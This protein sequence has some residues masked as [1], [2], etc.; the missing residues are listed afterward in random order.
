MITMASAS[1]RP[2]I[3]DVAKI[4]GVSY[5]TVSRY[6]NGS[7]HVSE[8]AANRIAKAVKETSYTPNS[9]ARSLAHRRTQTI[10]LI[11]Q[12]ES[13]ST[14][15]QS[16]IAQA[17]SGANQTLGE[18]GYQ[19]VT[20]IADSEQATQRITTLVN[21]DFA[22]GYLLFSMSNDDS[23]L[24]AFRNLRRPMVR[25]EISSEDRTSFLAVDF[26]NEQGQAAITRYLLNKHRTRLAYICGPGY[27]PTSLNRL[28]GFKTAMG[29][30]YDDNLVYY[31]DDWETTSGEMAVVAF[32]AHL[33]SIDGIVCANDNIAVGLINQLR[34]MGLRIPE[35][36]AV[37]GFD[38]STMALLANPKLTTVHQDSQLL[39]RTMAELVLRQIRGEESHT[40]IL[41]TRIVERQSA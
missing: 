24:K 3:R 2:T 31:A 26:D 19:M 11:I 30:L 1:K 18:A 41:K 40:T 29:E 4:A 37:T 32:E 38:D 15:M 6:F 28:A 35:D 21:G 5:G 27:S 12:V 25:S 36:I 39:G 22:D 20:L 34:H 16:S 10:A 33:H 8:A 13:N 9:S 7:E 23:L 14:I 17:I